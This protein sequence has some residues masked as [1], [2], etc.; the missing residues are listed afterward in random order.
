[1]KLSKCHH[2]ES[3]SLSRGRKEHFTSIKRFGD[4]ECFPGQ[5]ALASR[6]RIKYKLSGVDPCIRL[7]ESSHWRIGVLLKQG[8][9]NLGG[10][11]GQVPT[12]L[13]PSCSPTSSLPRY[14]AKPISIYC[15]INAIQ[16][17]VTTVPPHIKLRNFTVP[18]LRC[19]PLR[20][21]SLFRN[22]RGES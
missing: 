10:C 4:K 1:M 8:E 11:L 13:L 20:G 15:I 3:L 5:I 16:G 12:A 2:N 21:L 9:N 18:L 14:L 7:A 19:R 17:L 6:P 22:V